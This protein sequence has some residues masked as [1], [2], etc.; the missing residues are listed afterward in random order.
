M[1]KE[2]RIDTPPGNAPSRAWLRFRPEMIGIPDAVFTSDEFRWEWWNRALRRRES[3]IRA[4]WVDDLESRWRRARLSIY[5]VPRAWTIITNSRI[6]LN[7]N[8]KLSRQHITT[9]GVSCIKLS[10]RCARDFETIKSHKNIIKMCVVT[11]VATILWRETMPLPTLK[12]SNT[13]MLTIY[14]NYLIILVDQ[15]CK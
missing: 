5:K 8:V 11:H 14:I 12:S 10:S 3:E 1:S 13:H 15:N 6:R 4:V 9:H 2:H 7:A